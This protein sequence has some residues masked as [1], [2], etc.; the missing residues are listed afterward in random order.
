MKIAA[1]ILKDD[2]TVDII[3]PKCDMVTRIP[4]ER[5]PGRFLSRVKCRCRHSFIIK[6]EHRDKF[7]RKVNLQGFYEF[8][9]AESLD[10]KAGANV[11]W[12]SVHINR[13]IPSCLI[14]DLSR[15]GIGFVIIDHRTLAE[16]DIIDLTFNLDDSNETEIQQRCRVERVNDKQI[17]TSL[18]GRN[19]KLGFYLLG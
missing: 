19:V 3:C 17:G 11:R 14:T 2:N 18:I 8:T 4:L 15:Q 5:L 9:E 1:A 13:K 10:L 12:E 16:G 7:R 6:V